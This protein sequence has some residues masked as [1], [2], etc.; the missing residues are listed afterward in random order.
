MNGRDIA[1]M[2]F[3]IN[4]ESRQAAKQ[5]QTSNIPLEPMTSVGTEIAP[6]TAVDV[7]NV[8]AEPVTAVA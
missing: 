6:E 5:L 4:W 3:V 8:P 7:S 1:Q 2:L